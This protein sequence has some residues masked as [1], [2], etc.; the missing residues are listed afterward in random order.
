MTISILHSKN[1]YSRNLFLE[2]GINTFPKEYLTRTF[3]IM[4]SSLGFQVSL[5]LGSYLTAGFVLLEL[6]IFVYKTIGTEFHI[7]HYLCAVQCYY[8]Q[9][10]HYRPGT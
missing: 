2:S 9:F 6:L 4:K 7:T 1:I 8:F 10:C 3:L 5:Y